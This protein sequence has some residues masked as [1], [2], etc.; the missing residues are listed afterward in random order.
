MTRAESVELL[1]GPAFWMRLLH[2][3]ASLLA[4]TAVLIAPASPSVK[5][6]LLGG[7]PIVHMATSRRMRRSAEQAP[8]VRLFEDGKA[9]IL[10]RSG[11]VP[12]LLQGSVWSSRW[13]S[14]FRL[15]RLD[16]RGSID[17]IVCRSVNPA[18][19]YRRLR[20]MLRLRSVQ[21]PAAR[22]S[23]Q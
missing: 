22:W 13:F 10:T 1:Q 23:W 3:A 11:A 16:G 2:L 12:A 4:A 17:C 7:L 6:L 5:L 8:R 9:S 21:D 14:A 20:V 15:K 19:A 18:D